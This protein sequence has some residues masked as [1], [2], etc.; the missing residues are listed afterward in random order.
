MNAAAAISSRY[1][2]CDIPSRETFQGAFDRKPFPFFHSVHESELFSWPVLSNLA[3][4]AEAKS[5]GYYFESGSTTPG[6]KWRGVPEG[7][8]LR[9]VLEN[10][11][12]ANSLI[13][14]KRVQEYE[15]YTGFLKT[16][17]DELGRLCGVDLKRSYR[18]PV[19]TILITSPG[20]VTP[21]HIDGEANF[22]MQIQGSKTVHIFNGNDD[23]VLSDIEL[24]KFW[25]GDD[26][27]APQY[28]QHLQD[29][30]WRFE[31]SPGTGVSNPVTFPHWVENGSSVSVSL[32][33]NFKRV[34]DP[35]ADA[36]R[37][38]N[39]LRKAGFHPLRPGKSPMLDSIKSGGY[40]TLRSLK[41]LAHR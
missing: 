26:T 14:L 33:M 9:D 10:I 16:C 24:E 1:F 28:R 3:A 40:Q 6:E 38:N 11:G 36:Y 30:A 17:I 4:R 29:K 19:M 25:S 23:E 2:P 37:I 20:R 41:R 18:D 32:S 39:V 22:L 15:E 13:M 31:L 5:G 21:Y 8:S 12:E 34:S 27:K 35:T 7:K